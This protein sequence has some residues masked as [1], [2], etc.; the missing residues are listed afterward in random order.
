MFLTYTDTSDNLHLLVYDLRA[1]IPTPSANILVGGNGLLYPSSYGAAY[2]TRRSQLAYLSQLTKPVG[3]PVIGLVDIRHR[4]TTSWVSSIPPGYQPAGITYSPAEDRYYLIGEWSGN[5]TGAGVR[6][7]SPAGPV[8]TVLALDAATGQLLWARPVPTCQSVLIRGTAGALIAH[9]DD[10]SAI[11]FACSASGFDNTAYP[12]SQGIA[13]IWVNKSATNTATEMQ[14]PA[15]VFPVSGVYF[16]G[17]E[18][19][20][21]VFDHST[22]RF[23][24]QSLSPTT[25]GA[26]VFDG[27]ASAWLGFIPAANLNDQFTGLNEGLH[28]VYIASSSP[29]TPDATDG[30]VVADA[31]ALPLQPGGV[32]RL[33]VDSD[34]VAD[35]GSNRMFYLPAGDNDGHAPYVV[36]EDRTPVSLPVPPINYDALTSDA[37]EDTSYVSYAGDANGY[38][39]EVGLVGGTTAPTTLAGEDPAQVVASNAQGTGVPVDAVPIGGGTRAVMAAR[40]GNIDLRPAGAAGSAQALVADAN[41]A[42]NVQNSNTIGAWPYPPVTCL[43]AGGGQVKPQS[44]SADGGTAEVTC[45]LAAQKVLADAA[46]A[47]LNVGPITV[48]HSTLST[49][50]YRDKKLGI[51]TKSTSVATGI[52]IDIPGGDTLSIG[53]IE[54]SA[55]TIGHGRR[56]TALAE[57]SRTISGLSLADAHGKVLYS[58]GTCS[59]D[60]S[61]NGKTV[62]RTPDQCASVAQQVS[63]LLSLRARI[64]LPAPD[65]IA[66]PRGAF[67][68]IQQTDRDYYEERTMND[69]GV[70]Y[71]NDSVA[72]RP[73]A[74]LQVVLYNDSTERSRVVAQFAAVQATTVYTVS[75]AEQIPNENPPVSGSTNPPA[76]S[77]VPQGIAPAPA[78]QHGGLP[79]GSSP[80]ALAPSAPQGGLAGWLFRHRSVRDALLTASVLTLIA[81]T[82]ALATRR[83]ALLALSR[84]EE[85]S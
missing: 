79:A 6:Q 74:G 4:T 71:Q 30:V 48:S 20:A 51:I 78:T 38:G 22:D 81:L 72:Q 12:G 62:R 29:G 44:H 10:Q 61:A 35:P 60:V 46:H 32:A 42:N 69:Q 66:T 59:A 70:V 8:T 14:L 75:P 26:W 9:S 57:W 34:V 7:Y 84:I 82:G 1:R 45:D 37:P 58:A 56:G 83:R 3:T 31:D 2:D 28:H 47:A 27:R 55:T 53:R 18:Q 73:V 68:A 43:D 80:S 24:L 63:S 49:M 17:G 65:A 23:F 54:S 39:A 64:A 13:R 15:E 11:Y 33:V 52:R 19:G 21:A 85:E 67:A 16:N 40:I 50:S 41:T 77:P 76:G 25:P 36:A 5:T